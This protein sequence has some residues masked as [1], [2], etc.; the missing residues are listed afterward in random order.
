MYYN[1]SIAIAKSETK[2]KLFIIQCLSL[3]ACKNWLC[4]ALTFPHFLW[5]LTLQFPDFSR[6]SPRRFHIFDEESH[7]INSYS[8]SNFIVRSFLSQYYIYVD[9]ACCYQPSSVV[10]RAVCLSVTRVSRTKTAEPIEM[11]FGLKTWVGPRNH[12]CI[13]WGP[14]PPWK[15]AIL[16]GKGRPIV[17][18]KDTL[19]SSV[20]KRLNQSRWHLDAIWVVGSDGP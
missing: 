1:C 4:F 16:R 6:F 8:M 18:Y 14:D 13:R 11:P 20:Q 12:V 3:W 17:K 2:L 9:A 10:C 19:Q 5:P 7:N 15:G